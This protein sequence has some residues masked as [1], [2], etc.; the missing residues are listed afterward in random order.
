VKLQKETTSK[1]VVVRTRRRGVPCDL[2]EYIA[3]RVGRYTRDP[4]EAIALA[5][6]CRTKEKVDER[7]ELLWAL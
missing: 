2:A 5:R 7:V 1:E 3:E 6:V 4:R